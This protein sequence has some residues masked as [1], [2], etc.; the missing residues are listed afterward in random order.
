M[1]DAYEQDYGTMEIRIQKNG[2]SAFDER[3]CLEFLHHVDPIPTRVL[4]DS[5][6]S[7]WHNFNTELFVLYSSKI[8][9]NREFYTDSNGLFMIKRIYGEETRYN[10]P[11]IDIEKNLYPINKLILTRDLVNHMEIGINV[12]RPSSAT[13]LPDSDIMISLTRSVFSDDIKGMGEKVE[14]L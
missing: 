7:E 12:D 3:F 2:S 13:V 10:E 6:G 5:A 8:K 11:P 14:S 9:N 1:A 4:N